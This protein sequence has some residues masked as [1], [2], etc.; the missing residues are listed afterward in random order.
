MLQGK[1]LNVIYQYTETLFIYSSIR[2]FIYS[3]LIK[4]IM[5]STTISF[6]IPVI[7]DG[8]K[9][10]FV[11]HIFKLKNIGIVERVDFV[12]NKQK[13]RREAFV[14]FKEYFNNTE[15]NKIKSII[16][17]SQNKETFPP[18]KFYYKEGRFWALLLNKNPSTSIETRKAT[19]IYDIE[20]QINAIKKDMTKLT[21]M[22]KVH[23][24]N[25]R[26]ILKQPNTKDNDTNTDKNMDKDTDTDTDKDKDTDTDKDTDKNKDTDNADADEDIA[27]KRA[28]T[29]TD[30]EM[31]TV[32]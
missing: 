3:S 27:V 14:H 6:Y 8:I 5:A 2:L 17:S 29:M 7:A 20:E 9:E 11:A 22:A 28:K 26:F 13:L 4:Y 25:I 30:E 23:D 18:Y 31:D 21:F 10:E 15:A 16:M 24:A 32:I 1:K 19:N 12:L